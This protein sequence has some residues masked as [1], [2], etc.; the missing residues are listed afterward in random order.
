M[1]TGAIINK[2]NTNPIKYFGITMRCLLNLIM[3]ITVMPKNKNNPS[4]L[5]H[6]AIPAKM[7]AQYIIFSFL[8]KN[9]NIVT[10]KVMMNSGSALPL[11]E[12]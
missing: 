1:L 10:I 3:N 8:F 2:N 9:N 4:G 12:F 6:V 5:I 11:N 7:N